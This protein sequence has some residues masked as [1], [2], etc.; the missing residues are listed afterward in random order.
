LTATTPIEA[1][2]SN[3]NITANIQIGGV[4]DTAATLHGE[5]GYLVIETEKAVL[6]RARWKL[7]KA[8]GDEL[9]GHAEVTEALRIADKAIAQAT[10]ANTH[11]SCDEVP[12]VDGEGSDLD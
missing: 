8:Q 2:A 1:S 5:Y 4:K 12:P 6:D 7:L 3:P 11:P 9:L 10:E